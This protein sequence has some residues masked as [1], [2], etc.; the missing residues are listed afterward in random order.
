MNRTLQVNPPFVTSSHSNTLKFWALLSAELTALRRNWR[1]LLWTVAFPPLIFVASMGFGGSGSSP[2][3]VAMLLASAISIGIFALGLFGYASMLATY[4]DQGVFRRL[5]C[6]PVPGWMLLMSKVVAQ[7]VAVLLQS[8]LVIVVAVVFYHITLTFEG[9]AL[10]LVG[11]VLG[12]LAALALGQFIASLTR[13]AASVSAIARLTLFGLVFLDGSLLPIANMPEPLAV[14]ATWS[15]IHLCLV[16]VESAFTQSWWTLTNLSYTLA[17]LGYI[18]L[19]SAVSAR[20]FKWD[21][22]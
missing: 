3:I 4:R 12:G 14:L 22:R 7:L 2:A 8:V 16:V 5:R 15:P 17:L 20:T 1:L 11:V 6:T 9:V 10:A 19:L 13:S 21:A 18:V